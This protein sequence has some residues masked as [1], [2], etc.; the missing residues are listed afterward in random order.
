MFGS[1]FNTDALG[2][3]KDDHRMV[4]ELLDRFEASRD[5]AEMAMLA[6]DICQALILHAHIEEQL[7]YPA[8]RAAGMAHELLEEAAVEHAM[9]AR[10]IG[11]IDGASADGELF[12]ARVRVLGEY[13]AHHV[14][15]EENEIMTE[16]RS[17]DI[18]L[19]ALGEEI[20][21]AKTKLETKLAE[22]V[23]E[24]GAHGRVH[25]LPVAELQGG[26]FGSRH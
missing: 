7:F 11:E 9:L 8:L 13:V 18:D 23:V 19:D 10:L 5:E 22:V 20:L 16:A 17:L 2:L 26:S 4:E 25:V 1:A 6:Q 12:Q 15:Q 14:E 24:P 3:L 21:V